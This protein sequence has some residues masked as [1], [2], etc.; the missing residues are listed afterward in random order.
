MLK[1]LNYPK[2]KYIEFWKQIE[3]GKYE[4]MADWPVFT[5]DNMKYNKK[6]SGGRLDEFMT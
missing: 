3:L 4:K 1:T 6:M 2:H 5:F